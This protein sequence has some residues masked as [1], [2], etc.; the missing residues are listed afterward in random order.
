MSRLDASR[1]HFTASN[2]PYTAAPATAASSCIEPIPD[3]TSAEGAAYLDAVNADSPGWTKITSEIE[4]NG[5]QFNAQ[6]LEQQST[7]DTEFLRQL[8]STAFSGPASSYAGQLEAALRTYVSALSTAQTEL[9]QSGTTTDALN[10]VLSAENNA[11]ARASADL[12]SALSLRP[13]SCV[14]ERP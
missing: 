10:S 8:Q 11:R 3:G 7:V 14:I 9:S 4:A 5:G 6:I 12:R 13:S 1:L 2:N